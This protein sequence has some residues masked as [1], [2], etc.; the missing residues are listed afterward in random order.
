MVFNIQYLVHVRRRKLINKLLIKHTFKVRKNRLCMYVKQKRFTRITVNAY[1]PA[2]FHK[3]ET[4][5]IPK[6][7][8]MK[9]NCSLINFIILITDRI[10]HIH[11]I[12]I[13]FHIIPQS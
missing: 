2:I 3:R 10:K 1:L 5:E 6:F 8:V 13:V 9:D 12:S 11:E 4:I 7:L